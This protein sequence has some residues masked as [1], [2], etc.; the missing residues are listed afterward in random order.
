MSE[1][2]RVKLIQSKMLSGRS[3]KLCNTINCTADFL[4]RR[5]SPEFRERY[6]GSLVR[7]AAKSMI[8]W[9]LVD[10]LS[11]AEDKHISSHEIRGNA[12]VAAAETNRHQ[13]VNELLAENVSVK[14]NT[15][16]FGEVF[17]A[18]ASSGSLSTVSILLQNCTWDDREHL[19]NARYM[20]AVQ[21][22]AVA[23]HKDIVLALLD[24]G[25]PFT[26]SLYDDAIVRTAKTSQA[27]MAELLL[28]RRQQ[29]SD[30]NIERAFWA[31]LIRSTVEGN[32]R[33]LL[34]YLM[35]EGLS[36]IGES[37]IGLAVEDGCRRG[38]Y[39]SVEILLSAL[40][41]LRARATALYTGGLFWLARSGTPESLG[42]FM[43][44]FQQEMRHITRALAGAISGKRRP[45]ITNLLRCA[46]VDITNQDPPTRFTDAIRLMLPE[47][48]STATEECSRPLEELAENLRKS[49][50]SDDL[51]EV[52]KIFQT[53]KTQHPNSNLLLFAAAFSAAAE[54]NHSDIL[55]YLCENLTPHLVTDCA[56]STAVLRIF[57]DFGWDFNQGDPGSKFGRLG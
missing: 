7:L 13:L 5:T 56:S 39:E 31:T 49:S 54:N 21:A 40:P 47:A 29:H 55:L 8:Y 44:P 1:T 41:S 23:G 46:G 9:D 6:V 12:L 38:H 4:A 15:R 45:T 37:S 53:A 43:K 50:S 51:V 19:L 11:T 26:K 25:T 28:S 35:P 22:A 36:K 42:C 18:A 17:A 57:M 52:I 33:E 24:R 14:S 20:H 48:F 32:N 16:Y 10:C 2:M 27:S 30:S 3:N 34:L